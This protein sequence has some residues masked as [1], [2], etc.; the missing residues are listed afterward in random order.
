MLTCTTDGDELTKTAT[1]CYLTLRYVVTDLE[2]V[3][4][5]EIFFDRND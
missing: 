4:D 3:T 1:V 5:L 2:R